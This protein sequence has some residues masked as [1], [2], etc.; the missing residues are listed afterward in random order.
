MAARRD[1]LALRLTALDPACCVEDFEAVA[2]E[3]RGAPGFDAAL[4]RAKALAD[5]KRLLAASVLKR[6]GD[7]CACEIQAALGVSHATV[8]H[9]MAC[10]ESA[11]LVTSEKRGKWVHY[12]VV[13]AYQSLI[14]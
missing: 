13:P 1:P 11:G 9:H 2:R 14:P 12:R 7:L 8:S 3:A 4:L 5:E 6:R 10:L